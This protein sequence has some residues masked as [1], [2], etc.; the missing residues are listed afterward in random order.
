MFLYIADCQVMCVTVKTVLFFKY[1][2]I[3]VQLGVFVVLFFARSRMKILLC[4]G[5][6]KGD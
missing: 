5:K 1:I 4:N 2:L 6:V 3:T